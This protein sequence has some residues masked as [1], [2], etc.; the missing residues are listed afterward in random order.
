MCVYSR[1]CVYE[2]IICRTAFTFYDSHTEQLVT[3]FQF[4]LFRNCCTHNGASNATYSGKHHTCIPC[5]CLWNCVLIF[6]FRTQSNEMQIKR[7]GDDEQQRKNPTIQNALSINVSSVSSRS[8]FL[9]TILSR[10]GERIWLLLLLLLS[11][12]HCSFAFIRHSCMH[13]SEQRLRSFTV[14]VYH[15][16]GSL[17][18]CRKNQGKYAGFLVF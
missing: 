6:R 11:R 17:S 3:Q 14:L 16:H 8:A 4:S 15:I 1:V 7:N 5:M 2:C 13:A 9:V 12:A 18:L 10:T